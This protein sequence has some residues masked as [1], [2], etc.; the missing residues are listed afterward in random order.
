MKVGTTRTPTAPLRRLVLAVLIA[1]ATA[2]AAGCSMSRSG[3]QGAQAQPVTMLRVENQGYLDMNVYVVEASGARRRLGTATGS[4]T[5]TMRIP[6]NLL[7]GATQL[8]F[9][10]DPIGGARASVSQSITVLPGDTVVM[11]IPPA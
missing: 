10:A 9:I 8:R 3:N 2:G 11:T 4:S 5:T 6:P 7:F 1:A